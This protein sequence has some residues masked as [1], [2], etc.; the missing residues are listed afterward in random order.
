MTNS[1]LNKSSTVFLDFDNTDSI[2][3]VVSVIDEKRVETENELMDFIEKN[4]CIAKEM[5]ESTFLFNGKD[6]TNSENTKIPLNEEDSFFYVDDKLFGVIQ[7][8]D[9]ENELFTV[10]FRNEV[11]NYR[12]E[13]DLSFSDVSSEERAKITI[14]ARLIY[15]Y[16]KLYVKGTAYNSAKVVFRAENTWNKYKIK[17]LRRKTDKLLSIFNKYG[18]Q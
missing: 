15:L 3:D 5:G 17:E 16:G 6:K 2:S 10:Q 1:I 12:R 11:D 13:A 14:G 8:I 18:I 4:N 7:S 9:F